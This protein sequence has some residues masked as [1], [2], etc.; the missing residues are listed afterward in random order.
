V[1]VAWA[2]ART[3]TGVIVPLDSPGTDELGRS[4][5]PGV[6]EHHFWERFG[7][8]LLISIVD[9]AVQAGVQAS[10]RSG[11]TVVYA[12]TSSQDVLTEVLKGSVNIAPT[13]VKRN[14]DRIQVLVARDVDFRPVYELHASGR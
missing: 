3:P 5:L 4:G 1:F 2:E 14:G 9:G 7:A 11:G 13:V 6:V 10:S 12:P 8:A